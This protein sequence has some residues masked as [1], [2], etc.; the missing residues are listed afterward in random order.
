MRSSSPAPTAR[1]WRTEESRSGGRLGA[2]A[3]RS[4]RVGPGGFRASV[5]QRPD[6][7]GR[8]PRCR[9]EPD[10]VLARYFGHRTYLGPV[11]MAFR[12]PSNPRTAT[13]M[14]NQNPIAKV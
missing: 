9:A 14:P 13:A 6:G 7:D 10:S 8:W 1:W 2:L 4:R 3:H 11:R 5:T 12:L